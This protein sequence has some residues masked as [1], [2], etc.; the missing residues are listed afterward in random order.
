MPRASAISTSRIALFAVVLVLCVLFFFLLFSASTPSPPSSDAMTRQPNA[1]PGEKPYQHESAAPA[2]SSLFSASDLSNDQGDLDSIP[3]DHDRDIY[4]DIIFSCFY[5]RNDF[6]HGR[7]MPSL[8]WIVVMIESAYEF[9]KRSGPC[10][11]QH[12]DQNG[13]RPNYNLPSLSG[14]C[15][16]RVVLFVDG[17]TKQRLTNLILERAHAKKG[18]T[19]RVRS[20]SGSLKP[21]RPNFIVNGFL[22]LVDVDPSRDSEFGGVY[23][24]EPWANPQ[25]IANSANNFRFWLIRRYMRDLWRRNLFPAGGSSEKE[26]KKRALLQ[27]RRRR[28]LKKNKELLAEEDDDD[29]N[30]LASNS[31]SRIEINNETTTRPT[32]QPERAHDLNDENQQKIVRADVERV[33]I[34]ASAK[35]RATLTMI[36]TLISDA[37]DVLF[38]RNPFDDGVCFPKLTATQE[39]YFLYTLEHSSK[40]F[41]NEKYNRRWMKCYDKLHDVHADHLEAQ[42]L[43]LAE[44]RSKARDGR[45]K[46]KK[47]S[48]NVNDDDGGGK[49]ASPLGEMARMKMRI[50]CAGVSLGSFLGTLAYLNAQLREISNPTLTTCSANEINATLD[51]ATHNYLMFRGIWKVRERMSKEHQHQQQQQK[52]VSVNGGDSWQLAV[53]T[54]SQSQRQFHDSRHQEPHNQLEN[55][56][57]MRVVVAA[58]PTFAERKRHNDDTSIWDR[59]SVLQAQVARDT[60]SSLLSQS[61]AAAAGGEGHGAGGDE[62]IPGVKHGAGEDSVAFTPPVWSM[63]GADC[64]FHGNF[65]PLTLHGDK[66]ISPLSAVRLND[67]SGA[68]HEFAI[69]H[70]YT[71]DRHPKVMSLARKRYGF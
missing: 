27:E 34:E 18:M 60:T 63:E 61:T 21:K 15:E 3:F 16:M 24:S 57:T 22:E 58:V 69:V 35:R 31:S 28:Y 37:T 66:V 42:Q 32:A 43:T 1:A 33:F 36:R 54:V 19:S 64:V 55:L 10:A 25:N 47:W 52:F 20:S 2:K 68:Y 40:N 48:K 46:R 53:R 51:Q 62:E 41:K 39:S 23:N 67:D 13:E 12:D 7:K 5:F 9:R 6:Y 29:N 17:A 50:S 65:A 30:S 45:A 11:A 14:H 56:H 70:Q 4:R 8:D 71:S 26:K 49:W 59:W 44:E 38:Q